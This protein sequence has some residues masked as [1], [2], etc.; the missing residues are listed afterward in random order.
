MI[1][2]YVSSTEPDHEVKKTNAENKDII[3]KS[4][5]SMIIEVVHNTKHSIAGNI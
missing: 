1:Y 2:F 3:E 5:I 4:E